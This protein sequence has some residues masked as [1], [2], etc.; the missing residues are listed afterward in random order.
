[1]DRALRRETK[2]VRRNTLFA[3]AIES[4]CDSDCAFARPVSAEGWTWC[5][6]PHV[7][8]MRPPVRLGR[9]CPCFTAQGPLDRDSS[10]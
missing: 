6:S 8:A 1:M 4:T 3:Q 5:V 10:R 2:G 9:A 7:G